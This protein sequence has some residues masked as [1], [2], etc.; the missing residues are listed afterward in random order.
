M[1]L[2]EPVDPDLCHH[3]AS[4]GQNEL[5]CTIIPILIILLSDDTITSGNNGGIRKRV[6]AAGHSI[7]V[8]TGFYFS[9]LQLS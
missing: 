9:L 8:S 5:M 1:P 6:F 2:P 4:L 3:M 7:I